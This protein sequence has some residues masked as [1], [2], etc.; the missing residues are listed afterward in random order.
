MATPGSQPGRNTPV[1]GFLKDDLNLKGGV[2]MDR[3]T[4]C[5]GGLAVLVAGTWLVGASLGT[6]A[7]TDTVSGA[8]PVPDANLARQLEDI[9][10]G[11]ST[12]LEQAEA[13]L[14]PHQPGSGWTR[15]QMQKVLDILDG[16]NAD[17]K[18]PGQDLTDARPAAERVSRETGES[19]DHAS[20]YVHEAKTHAA[21]ALQGKTAQEIHGHARLAAGLL[22]AA[23]GRPASSSP[24]TG[25][26]AY[27]QKSV[28]SAGSP[29]P[30]P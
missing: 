9:A 7:P 13:S 25:A 6:A 10:R 29:L 20:A 22:A 3:H 16:R 28:E 24:V 26:L 5:A 15:A 12:A 1:V 30:R 2:I 18:S 8:E 23:I 19:L 27:A 4:R 11:L 14:K 17:G 21:Q